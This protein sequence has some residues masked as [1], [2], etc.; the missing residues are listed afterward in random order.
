[1]T[2]G[3][4]IL[5][6]GLLTQNLILLQG[7]GM[8]ALT[9][10]T[11]SVAG[12]AKAGAGMLGAM[13]TAAVGVWALDFVAIPESL[14]LVSYL[15]VAGFAAFLWQR[16]FSESTNLTDGLLDS[17][18]VGLLLLLARDHISGF[19]A[20]GYAISAGLGYFLVL[21][22]IAYLRHQLELAPIPKAFRGVPL[23]LITA[24][25]L[26]MALLGFKL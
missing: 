4:N 16:I 2:N 3:L 8:Y 9:R 25:L 14:S 24:G 20:V 1:M 19:A 15:I 7:L 21:T 13:V 26:G 6:S 5:G 18:L 10:H 23:V 17:A 11:K 12:A 22:V